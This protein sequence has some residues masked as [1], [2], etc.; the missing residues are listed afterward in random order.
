MLTELDENYVLV[1]RIV[2]PKHFVFHRQT[3]LLLVLKL[4]TVP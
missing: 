3:G 4:L 2:S 1:K